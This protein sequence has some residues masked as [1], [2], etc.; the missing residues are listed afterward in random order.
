L[1]RRAAYRIKGTTTYAGQPL[2][3]DL[4]VSKT[5]ARGSV[6][7]GRDEVKV[8]RVGSTAYLKGAPAGLAGLTG[9]PRDKANG[10]GRDSWLAVPVSTTGSAVVALTDPARLL[11]GD[12]PKLQGGGFF[13][14]QSVRV[15]QT[16]GFGG[17]AVLVPR[18]GTTLVGIFM[19]K[20]ATPAVAVADWPAGLSVKPPAKSRIVT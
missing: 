15:V 20:S 17:L 18:D 6:T 11:S 9:V 19:D 4:T 10:V 3:V 13:R 8:L 14:G 1:G 5:A 7:F 2:A 12:S 16:G